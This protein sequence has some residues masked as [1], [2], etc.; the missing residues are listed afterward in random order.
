MAQLFAR[1][2]LRGTPG[3]PVHERLH[4]YMASLNWYQTIDGF[5]EAG[6]QVTGH[7]LMQP[8]GPILY[9]MTLYR[10]LWLGN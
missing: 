6:D 7:C 9:P 2:E 1:I 10:L 8:I 5:T 3:E 4:A